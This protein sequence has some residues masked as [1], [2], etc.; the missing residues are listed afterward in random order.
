MKKV[1]YIP[2]SRKHYQCCFISHITNPFYQLKLKDAAKTYFR[3]SYRTHETDMQSCYSEVYQVIS[4][5]I[6]MKRYENR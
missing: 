1:I 5:K 6:G 3:N 2:N 4:K